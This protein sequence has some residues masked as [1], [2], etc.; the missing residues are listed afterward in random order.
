MKFVGRDDCLRCVIRPGLLV[1]SEMAV[2][3]LLDSPL[4][5]DTI[6]YDTHFF[7]SEGVEAKFLGYL[8]QKALVD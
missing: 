8:S 6:T 2:R 7:R 3:K 4:L 5:L 1:M